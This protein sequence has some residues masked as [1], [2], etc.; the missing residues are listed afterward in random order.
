[1]ANTLSDAPTRVNAV[2]GVGQFI[3][4]NGGCIFI[5]RHDSQIPVHAHQAIQLV[6]GRSA[7]ARVHTGPQAPWMEYSAAIIASRQ[8]HG[9]DVRESDYGVVL[10]VE[11]ETRAGQ[12]IREQHLQG[13]GVVEVGSDSLMSATQNLFDV[14]LEQRGRPAIAEAAQKVVQLLAAGVEPAE[15]TDPR[16]LNAIAY[17]NDHIADEL[18]LDD[19]ASHAYLSPSRFRHLFVEQTGMGL[20]P[21]ILWRRFLHVWDLLMAGQ[22]LSSA[23]HS[24]GFADAAHLTRTSRRTF[25]FVPSAMLITS[26]PPPSRDAM[27]PRE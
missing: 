7:K 8:P 14:W 20:R 27:S 3:A 5:G 25:G 21:Y 16:I 11:P 22:T 1:V 24:A 23:A 4:W 13:E 15:V 17:I 26:S 10:F 19:V 2:V 9:L 18:T 12:A 6:A